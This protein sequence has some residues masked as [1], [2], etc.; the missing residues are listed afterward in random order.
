M[1]TI[2]KSVGRNGSNIISDLAKIQL[3]LF[4]LKYLSKNNFEK[5]MK[6]NW[7]ESDAN[8][9]KLKKLTSA[10]VSLTKK[11][12][13]LP[14]T[15]K[16]ID[17]TKLT[18]TVNAIV[19]FQSKEV[20]LRRPDGRV[21]P[22]GKSSRTLN[23]LLKKLPVVV[24]APDV[25]PDS[26]D[27]GSGQSSSNDFIKKNG[28]KFIVKLTLNGKSSEKKIA[29]KDCRKYIVDNY[30][31][32]GIVK[33]MQYVYKK[34]KQEYRQ[35]SNL[36]GL[37]EDDLIIIP[38]EGI[39]YVIN[40][41]IAHNLEKNKTNKKS[42]NAILKSIDGKPGLGFINN[43]LKKKRTNFFNEVKNDSL[44]N[45]FDNNKI[46][47]PSI[48]DPEDVLYDFFRNIVFVRNGLWSDNQGVVNVVGLRRV[49]DRMSKTQ[50]NDGIAVCWLDEDGDKKVELSIAT[51][52]PGNRARFRQ[53]T[54]QTITLV[55]GYHN[56][57]QTA[58]R[59]RNAVKQA[60]NKG[61]LTW[62][63]GDTTMNFHQG[64]NRF[65]FPS[66]YWLTAYGIDDLVQ[67]GYPNR[68]FDEEQIFSV[69]ILLTKMFLLL[70]KYGANK[71]SAPY[72]VLQTLAESKP[73]K[74]SAPNNG[75]VT[76]SQSGVA[77]K[78]KIDILGV[79]KWMVNYWYN[80]RML[81][82]NRLKIFTIIQKLSNWDENRTE[83]LR[84]MSK[85]QILGEIKD[86]FILKIIEK[87]TE[88]FPNLSDIDGKA[89]PIFW[90]VIEDLR[91]SIAQAK[92]D[93]KT[94][95]KYLKDLEKFPFRKVSSL[96]RRFRL[97]LKI[98]S[99][100]NRENIKLHTRYNEV[101]EANVIENATVGLYSAGCQV[102]YDTEVFYEFWNKLM[103]RAES[104]GQR[105]WYYTLVDATGWKKTDVV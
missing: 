101:I 18:S 15:N 102:I 9:E 76:I 67:K 10:K 81:K 20:K 103:L 33:L 79:K 16:K 35:T 72:K 69:N 22:G 23:K 84:K 48:D 37:K 80:K 100:V 61:K 47:I 89:G 30:N 46:T 14:K 66:K 11:I 43:I 5:Q 50:Y 92:E 78:K 28:D 32:N 94:M 96:Q 97:G 4:A 98:N 93:F 34:N 77:Q 91:P 26:F 65:D 82:V 25:I 38:D 52:E 39:E 64:G 29:I 90:R 27:Q 70:S 2:K 95:K 51:T 44:I 75:I 71:K 31:W 6:L 86:E 13:L 12:S 87:Q 73:F 58:G 62:S 21:D 99:D 74:V 41:Q 3:S 40:T 17:T 36:K 63:K 53:L 19:K 45:I 88:F 7:T 49:I 56:I 57:R 59:T 55:A 42:L 68:R 8:N 85:Q 104:S 60:A 24:D 1:I 54:P 83:E 105:R